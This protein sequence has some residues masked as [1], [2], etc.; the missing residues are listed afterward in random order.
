MTDRFHDIMAL[1]KT[2]TKGQLADH[3]GVTRQRISQVLQER[4]PSRWSDRY[5]ALQLAK[6]KERL[7]EKAEKAREAEEAAKAAAEVPAED[8]ATEEAPAEDI[9]AEAPSEETT[10]EQA[11]G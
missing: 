7:E 5:A 8:V 3:Y 4:D 9:A 6:A 10:E 2:M 1:A 11:E